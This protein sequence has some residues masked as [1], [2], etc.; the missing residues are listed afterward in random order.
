MM[1]AMT[2]RVSDSSSSFR[3]HDGH[4]C[5]DIENGT[6]ALQPGHDCNLNGLRILMSPNEELRGAVQAS[7]GVAGYATRFHRHQESFVGS[8]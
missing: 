6:L 5:A 3:P 7:P 4:T 2:V 1:G 8:A